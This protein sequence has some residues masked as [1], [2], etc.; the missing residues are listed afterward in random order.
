MRLWVPTA[1]Y[2]GCGVQKLLY[3]VGSVTL[4]PSLIKLTLDI[5]MVGLKFCRTLCCNTFQALK[6]FHRKIGGLGNEDMANSFPQALISLSLS[7]SMC[8]SLY[9]SAAAW[10]E[11]EGIS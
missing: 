4:Q 1:T 10:V 11:V 3:L 2:H 5:R 8:F 7:F 9:L 6:H